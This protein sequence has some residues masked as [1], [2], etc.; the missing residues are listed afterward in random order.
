VLAAAFLAVIP[1][2]VAGPRLAEMR[3]NDVGRPRGL[4]KVTPRGYN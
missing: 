4:H 2:Q 3:R 1:A